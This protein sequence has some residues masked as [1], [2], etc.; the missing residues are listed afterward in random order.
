LVLLFG[1]GLGNSG[2]STMQSTIILLSAAPG[3]R[4]RAVGILGL[5]IGS[6]PLGLLELGA[7]AAVVGAPAA[8]GLN[9]GVGLVLLLPVIVFT[10]LLSG[11][12]APEPDASS[13]LREEGE[14]RVRIDATF[15]P[16]GSSP[17]RGRQ[18]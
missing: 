4:G 5:C 9:A 10:P 15:S 3:M 12:K 14:A 18:G 13:P 11:S 8:I 7:V 16:P 6:T 2:F 1:V 17:A